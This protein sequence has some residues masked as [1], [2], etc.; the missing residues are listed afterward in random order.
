MSS[1]EGRSRRPV[2]RAGPKAGHEGDRAVEG[3]GANGQQQPAIGA[4]AESAPRIDESTYTDH[5]IGD[6]TSGDPRDTKQTEIKLAGT[7]ATWTRVMGICA[8]LSLFLGVWQFVVING[9]LSQMRRQS[10][11][12]QSS[13]S[14]A[15]TAAIQTASEE[16]AARTQQNRLISAN[17]R[18]AS[19]ASQQL[20]VQASD[21]QEDQRPI[22]GPDDD[23]I[24]RIATKGPTFDPAKSQFFWNW[25]FK[26]LGKTAA[27]R[28][29]IEPYMSL[30]GGKFRK[31]PRLHGAIPELATLVPG[32]S[33]VIYPERITTEQLNS[34]SPRPVVIMIIRYGDRHGH[35]YSEVLCYQA[36]DNGSIGSC[37]AWQM[38]EHMG[39]DVRV[40]LPKG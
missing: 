14:D 26:N 19:A 30:F 28:I 18:L 37:D 33:T 38:M 22:I 32:W 16:A 24:P 39:A 31:D 35:R 36:Y 29:V 7:I 23:D 15:R 20:A 6:E 40:D 27:T 13:L 8:G 34:R 2:A 9:Q 3:D 11:L 5:P 4:A 25:G 21:F 10:D 1:R 17:E 12:M